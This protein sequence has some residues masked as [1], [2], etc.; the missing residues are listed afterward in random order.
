MAGLVW[1]DRK[2]EEGWKSM[3]RKILALFMAA[4]TISLSACAEAGDTS[5]SENTAEELTETESTDAAKSEYNPM[6]L[7]ESPLGYSVEYNTDMFTLTSESHS[8]SFACIGVEDMEAPIYVAVTAYPDMDA[9]TTAKGLEL[10]TGRD[11]VTAEYGTFGEG[12]EAWMLHYDEEVDGREHYYS[13]FAVPKGDG[14]LLLEAGEYV[15]Y[16]G[17]EMVDGNIELIIDSFTLLDN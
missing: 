10:Q 8:D 16:E 2:I 4:L 3:K 6:V 5:L 11:D 9:E 13:Y 7:Y 15:G 12:I 14:T 17:Q 1:T